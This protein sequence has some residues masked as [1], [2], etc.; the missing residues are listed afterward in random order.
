MHV[1][2]DEPVARFGKGSPTVPTV[3]KYEEG[4]AVCEEGAIGESLRD[5]LEDQTVEEGGDFY[6]FCNGEL[7]LLD[8]KFIII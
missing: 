7:A 5:Q 6:Q 8:E 3:K 4:M 2:L 1:A